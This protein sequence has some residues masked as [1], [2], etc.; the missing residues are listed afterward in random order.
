MRCKKTISILLILI[1][2]MLLCSCKKNDL[3]NEGNG[4][5]LLHNFNAESS[6]AKPTELASAYLTAVEYQVNEIDRSE[7]TVSINLSVPVVKELIDDTIQE[8]MDKHPDA[9]YE[10]L[11]SLIEKALLETLASDDIEKTAATIEVPYQDDDGKMV[12]AATEEWT[13]L[14]YGELTSAYLE[15]FSQIGGEIDGQ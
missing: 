4:L 6:E 7:K 5:D 14:L 9:S 13:E 11:R 1:A 10:E 2:A 3:K 8:Q 12:L 15:A